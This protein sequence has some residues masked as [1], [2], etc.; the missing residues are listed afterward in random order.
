MGSCFVVM[1]LTLYNNLVTRAQTIHQPI[2]HKMA[3]QCE[4]YMNEMHEVIQ[5]Y[6]LTSLYSVWPP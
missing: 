3:V 1:Q 4:L 2:A 5:P 6:L